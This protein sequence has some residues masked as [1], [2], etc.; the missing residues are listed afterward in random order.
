MHFPRTAE[1]HPQR[2]DGAY[3]VRLPHQHRRVGQ[4]RAG[5]ATSSNTTAAAARQWLGKRARKTR[6][7]VA[8]STAPYGIHHHQ[9]WRR[10]TPAGQP[11]P[12]RLSLATF[13]VHP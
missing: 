11:T 13:N 12:A 7:G 8:A 2:G 4:K 9:A 10:V 6:R 5:S 3:G 1:I